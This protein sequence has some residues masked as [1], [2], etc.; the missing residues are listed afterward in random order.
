METAAAETLASL[1]VTTVRSIR[2][3]VASLSGGQRQSV[4]I[5]KAVLWN[6]QLVIMDEPTAALGVAQTA[7]VL[8]LVRRLADRGHAAL[9]VSH[10]MND[11]FEVADRIAVL[12]LGHMVAIRPVAEMDRQIAV[13]L[14]TTGESTRMSARRREQRRGLTRGQ[15]RRTRRPPP[16]EELTEAAARQADWRSP[17]IG[18]R[19]AARYLRA[20]L[21]RVRAGES[22]VLPVVGGLLLVSILFQSLNSHFLTA[23]NLVNLLVQARRVQPAGDGRGVRPAAGRDRPVDR[24]RGRHR[25]GGHG[26][27]GN[28]VR[29][30][31]VGGDRG[32]LAVCA[33]IGLLQGTIITRIG[34]PSFVVT[35][36]GPALLA[37]RDAEDPRQRRHD[38]DQQQRHQR[39]RQ[40][41][42]HPDRGLGGDARDGR[43][44]RPAGLAA[45]RQRR[46][47]GLVAPPAEPDV[48]KIGAALA[49]G[50][51]IVLLCNTEPGRPRPDLRRALGR[52]AHLRRA[53]GVDV[54]AGPDQFGRYIYAIGGNAEAARRAG[55]NLARIRTLAFAL[56]RS[57]PASPASSTPPACGPSRPPS[58]AARSC[59]TPSPPP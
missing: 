11:V 55:I 36:G 59:S 41:Q 52:A 44:V 30:A 33:A 54:P 47:A 56:P 45:R 29:L 40:R 46:A 9:I 31:L 15:G 38:P 7:M 50:V 39:H 12:H 24:L 4:A 48:A 1:A 43:P 5:A 6:T 26:G 25:R 34:L 28:R 51:A 8:A 42:P 3:P 58:T 35:L 10:N 17:R 53:R 37:G 49:G 23:G 57:R 19:V 14:M 32:R 21:A 2:Q 22:G 20:S 18:R 13:D 16:S 27:P